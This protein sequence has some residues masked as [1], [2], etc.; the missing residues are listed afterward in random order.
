MVEEP[1]KKSWRKAG[2]LAAAT[3]LSTILTIAGFYAW[4]NRWTS[5]LFRDSPDRQNPSLT[6]AADP[7]QA[8]LQKVEQDRGEPMGNNADIDIPAELKHYKDRR[9]FL[10]VQVAEWRRQKY[11]IPHDFAE[12]A[13]IIN[14]GELTRLTPLGP[15]YI[16]YGVGIKAVD[17]LTHYDQKTGKSIPLFSGEMELR[18]E[19]RRLNDS[20]AEL[21]TKT[22]DLKNNLAALAKGDRAASTDLL[23]QIAETRKSAAAIKLRR[24][25]IDSVYRSKKGRKLM[26]EEYGRLA[27]LA[28]NFDG[29]SFDLTDADSRK[30]FK[31]HLLSVLRPSARARLEEIA[32]V[33][34]QKFDRPLPVTS[35][36]RTNEY[37]RYLGEAGNPNATR[38]DV[39]PHTTGLAFD[40]YTYYMAADEQQFVLEEIARLKR[41]GRVEALRE[42]R[43]HIHVFAVADGHPPD[44]SLI[45]E[46]LK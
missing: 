21:E 19:L 33:Y 13:S 27:E 17:E 45:R 20:L 41:E 46:S 30:E 43:H 44:E 1:R 39:P 32:R 2:V 11:E 14:R 42:N 31:I 4:K 7:Y 9:R 5:S 10:A 24:D 6:I 22:L 36:M 23:T 15:S 25:L 18:D 29:Q 8:A 38:I 12:L 26:F 28:R 37:Q 3:V 16:L 34:Q 35:L 40:I